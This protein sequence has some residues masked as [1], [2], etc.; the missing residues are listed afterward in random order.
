MVLAGTLASIVLNRRDF[1]LP[2]YATY[3]SL[4]NR[5][6]FI[7]GGASGIGGNLVYQFVRQ[8]SKVAFFDI[9]EEAAAKTVD[10]CK[11]LNS[12]TEPLYLPGDVKDISCLQQAIKDVADKWNGLDVLINNAAN[13]DRH[14]WKDIDAAYWDERFET[15]LRHQFFAI[16]EA[17]SHINSPNGG[18]IINVGSSSWMIREDMFP[19]YAIAKSAVEGLTR[20]MA[21]TLGKDNIRV[22]SVLPGWVVTE[23]QLEKWWTEE[24]EKQT[25]DMQCLKKRIYP[26]EF[27]QLILFLAADDGGA[28]SGQSYLVDGGRR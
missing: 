9:D 13:D 5:R 22:N 10:N 17:A 26:E 11:Q 2:K 27:N 1:I 7:T 20:T 4:K 16:Q 3:P 23:R 12:Q 19:A 14:H 15:N 25:L 28:C 8:G 24:G 21:R 18:S 6:I